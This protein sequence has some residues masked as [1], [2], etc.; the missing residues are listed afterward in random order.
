MHKVIIAGSD[1]KGGIKSL[2]ITVC[3]EKGIE[4]IKTVT[5][6]DWGIT[7]DIKNLEDAIEYLQGR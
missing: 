6:E 2:T 5:F 4:G 3:Y 1:D 7:I